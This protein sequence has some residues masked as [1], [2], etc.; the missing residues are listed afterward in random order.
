F[1]CHFQET[2]GRVTPLPHD[3]EVHRSYFS[4]D[5]RWV[6]THCSTH[7]H[8]PSGSIMRISYGGGKVWDANTGV[9]ISPPCQPEKDLKDPELSGHGQWLLPVRQGGVAR[10]WAVANA[11]S[12]Q[13][14]LSL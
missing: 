2:N 7:G 12:M 8:F 4:Q 11:T 9:P 6:V 3:M 5:G 13:P 14:A 10:L 1:V